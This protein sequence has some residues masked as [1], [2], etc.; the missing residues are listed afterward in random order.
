LAKQEVQGRP[1]SRSRAQAAWP[2][3]VVSELHWSLTT[4]C[5]TALRTARPRSWACRAPGWAGAR[6]AD[7]A[8]IPGR[9]PAARWCA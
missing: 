6:S 9:A 4:V 2:R 1:G 8:A 7:L 5:S 3:V